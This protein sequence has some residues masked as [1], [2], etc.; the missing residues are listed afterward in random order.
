MDSRLGT[1]YLYIPKLRKGGYVPFLATER[2]RS[3]LALM[4]AHGVN[5][6]GDREILAMEPMFDESEGSWWGFSAN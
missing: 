1:V 6:A 5:G 2:K 3:V 4:F